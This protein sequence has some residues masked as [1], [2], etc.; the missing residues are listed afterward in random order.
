M[1][2]KVTPPAIFLITF[3]SVQDIVIYNSS[4]YMETVK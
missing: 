1:K 4:G 3:L 2:L